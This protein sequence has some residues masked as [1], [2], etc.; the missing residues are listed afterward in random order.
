MSILLP[1]LL[2]KFIYIYIFVFVFFLKAVLTAYNS[3]RTKTHKATDQTN[4]FSK[5]QDTN[6]QLYHVFPTK[7]V[8]LSVYSAFSFSRSLSL[9]H[10]RAHTEIHMPRNMLSAMSQDF[11][12]KIFQLKTSLSAQWTS[13][14]APFHK[15]THLYHT[16]LL[17]YT[18]IM[19]T[20]SASSLPAWLSLCWVVG[21]RHR[22]Y[23][24]AWALCGHSHAYDSSMGQRTSVCMCLAVP[25]LIRSSLGYVWLT[26]SARLLTLLCG[27]CW[28]GM[29]WATA[30]CVCVSYTY[31]LSIHTYTKYVFLHYMMLIMY[32]F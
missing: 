7:S 29:A 2:F 1:K 30:M 17:S 3:S 8:L 13:L 26:H 6:N 9:W 14:L 22:V 23:Q 4:A 27:K 28:H 19:P 11:I 12:A 10:K 5:Q 21:F 24:P 25:A 32:L 18:H 20:L 15:H 16:V 31:T